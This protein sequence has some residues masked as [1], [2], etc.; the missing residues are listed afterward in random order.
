M[1]LA[2]PTITAIQRT[3]LL[4]T[5]LTAMT[6]EMATTIASHRI[7]PDPT[8]TNRGA[9]PHDIRYGSRVNEGPHP[10]L[11]ARAKARG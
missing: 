4:L 5:A 8:G 11:R 6:S 10:R 2:I 3:T 7:S 1:A 9:Y